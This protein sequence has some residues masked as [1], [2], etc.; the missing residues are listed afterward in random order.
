MKAFSLCI[1]LDEKGF[2]SEELIGF[3]SLRE[4][5][6]YIRHNFSSHLDVRK[7]FNQEIS[8][9]CL[10]YMDRIVSENARNKNNRTGS[11][12]ILEKDYNEKNKLVQIRRIKVIYANQELLPTRGCLRRIKQVLED[13]EKL[14]RL[15]K[16]KSFLLSKNEMDLISNYFTFHNVKR[17]NSAIAFLTRG[18]SEADPDVVYYYCRC[19][20]NLCDLVR[21][22]VKTSRITVR[23][24]SSDIPKETEVVRKNDLKPIKMVDEADL[25]KMDYLNTLIKK[26][27]DDE[28]YNLYSLEEIE[29][30]K[31]RR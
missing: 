31:E 29:K 27:D 17:K 7:K 11:I 19:L 2:I 22:V 28:L 15:V 20:A 21:D 13:D 6:D 23:N 14:E 8:E 25:L 1:M 16:E 30:R 4:L 3:S 24:I 12:I 5:D 10:E 9:F 18:I 26:G